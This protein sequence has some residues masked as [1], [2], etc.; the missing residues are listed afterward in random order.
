VI[1]RDD[2]AIVRGY[3]T[4]SVNLGSAI[5][6]LGVRFT[7]YPGPGVSLPDLS[8]DSI[9]IDQIA[10]LNVANLLG[11]TVRVES[12][13]RGSWEAGFD[14][15]ETGER[16]AKSHFYVDRLRAVLDLTGLEKHPGAS[17]ESAATARNDAVVAATVDCILDNASRSDPPIHTLELSVIG[18]QRYRHYAKVYRVTRAPK[19]KQY[20]Y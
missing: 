3:V 9:S 12:R 8:R 17:S 4:Y 6:G 7:C 1:S 10:N 5:P 14:T 18:T 20:P 13:Q 15:S 11:L 16:A 2:R 19:P